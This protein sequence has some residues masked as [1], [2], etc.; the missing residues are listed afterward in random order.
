MGDPA[1]PAPCVVSG[2]AF[3]IVGSAEATRTQAEPKEVV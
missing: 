3:G 1:A 2:T